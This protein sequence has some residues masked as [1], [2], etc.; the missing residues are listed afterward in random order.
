MAGPEPV[1]LDVRV[2]LT[3]FRREMTDAQRL[4]RGFGSAIGDAL[5]GGVVKGRSL[6]DVLKGLGSRLSELALSAAL[7]PAEKAVGGMFSNL[8]SSLLGGVT[9]MAK[10]GVLS[11][12]TVLSAGGAALALAG[13]AGPEAVLPLTRG[14]DG[15]LGVA[16]GG[17]GGGGSVTVNITTPDVEGFRRS[18]GQVSAALARA[19][20][21]GRRGL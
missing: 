14:A 15:R 18:E 17:G 10:G 4:A 19:V 9:P 3:G 20:A 6:S 1:S 2:D 13:E 7:R 5:E 21:R 11:A 12:P 8:V 16:S